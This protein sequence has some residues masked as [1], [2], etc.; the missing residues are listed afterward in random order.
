MQKMRSDLNRRS[1]AKQMA[2][3]RWRGRVSFC[4]LLSRFVTSGE[5][6]FIFGAW[7]AIP[8][9]AAPTER[10]TAFYRLLSAFIAFWGFFYFFRSSR[11]QNLPGW[12]EDKLAIRTRMEPSGSCAAK[13]GADGAERHPYPGN[14]AA[15]HAHDGGKS[16]LLFEQRQLHSERLIVRFN[17]CFV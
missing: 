13:R 6:F 9:T 3:V 8:E 12:E 17:W 15:K 1:G 7:R 14:G 16:N 11:W 4:H 10:C 5:Q 2:E